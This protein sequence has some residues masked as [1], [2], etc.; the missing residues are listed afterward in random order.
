MITRRTLLTSAGALGL[1]ACAGGPSLTAHPPIVFVHGNGDAASIWQTTI[2]RFESNGWPR[3]RL[4]AFDLPYPLARDD[5]S[6]PQPGRTST[7]E[8]MEF[9]RARV[10]EVLQA[11]GARQVVLVAN[12]RGGYAVRNYIQNASGA[13]KVSHA[14]LGGVPNHG[15]WNVTG[16]ASGSE[17]AGNGPF[18]QKLN[19]P[20]NAAGDEVTG[21]VKWLTIRSDS[22]DKFA[23][24]RGQWI[25]DPKLETGITYAGPELKGA[26]NVVI[27]RI[28]HRETSF[29]P[30]AFD[31]TFRFITGRA[32]ATVDVIPEDRVVLSGRVTGSG[33]SST[34]PGS[35]NFSNN[36]PLPGARLEIF[37]ID[38]ASGERR[39]A[40]V[41]AQAIGAD[42][43]WGPFTAQRDTPHEFVVAAPGYATT[44]IYRSPFP[45]ST[46]VLNL[47]P[48]RIPEGDRSGP[49]LVIFTRP[50]GYFD[51]DRDRMALDG[52]AALPGVL[53]G[54]GVASSRLKPT[55]A[56]R[57]IVGEFNGE[58]VVGRTWPT[59]QDHVTVLE[60]T[61]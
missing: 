47:R 29:S 20:K 54:A 24:P 49:A 17:F 35:G 51:P 37:A 5:D 53:P 44:H 12:S 57:A 30:A 55:G 43:R 41:H 6:R 11:T 23:Q 7:T 15:V 42:G 45:R 34:D 60:L 19:A 40:A 36:L 58:K 3:D 31:A 18:L 26:T 13:A 22:N 52:Q 4:H 39:G 25:G 2:W 16:R 48:E 8:H 1:S 9:L 14:I 56:P 27:P 28:D 32:P 33:V 59:A 38:P 50:R 10:D 46:S 61:Y 21:P